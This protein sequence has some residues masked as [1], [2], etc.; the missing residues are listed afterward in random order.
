MF[1]VF[2]DSVFRDSLF[3]CAANVTICTFKRLPYTRLNSCVNLN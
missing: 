1:L 3:F 2:G